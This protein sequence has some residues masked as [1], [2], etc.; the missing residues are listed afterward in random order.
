MK[1]SKWIIIGLILA[2]ALSV[3]GVGLYHI[4]KNE[5]YVSEG[6]S[7]KNTLRNGRK[8]KVKVILLAGQS[9]ASGCS[10]VEELEKNVSKE[11]FNEYKNGYSNI[12]INY[13]NDNGMNSSNEFVNVTLSQGVTEGY[14]GPELGMAE[15]LSELYPGEKIFIIK[16]AWGGTDM[17]KRWK[18]GEGDL[19][20]SF[21]KFVKISLEYLEM[22]N[23]DVDVV[24]TMWMQ[25]ESDA[26]LE[27]Y[28]SYK[29]NTINF[30]AAIRKDIS[31]YIETNMYFV[32]AYISDSHYWQL[33]KE[34]NSSKQEVC[35][36][37]LYNIC[38]DTIKEGLTYQN[39]PI[40]QPDLAHYDS[41]SE[42]KL[43]HLFAQT[44]YDA[45]KKE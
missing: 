41:I 4:K 6:I 33:Y 35:D 29:E 38:I 8:E 1:K 14:F 20:K 2:I 7:I 32:D 34:I 40:D 3:I 13:Y 22:K 25:G 11:K 12:Y 21:I 37:S 28:P 23:Y 5:Y 44:Y 43:G 30:I 42:V 17:Y 39:E 27:Y 9:N 26:N 36:S 45:T 31:K 24:A 19:Y 15:K 10:H 18:A 16:S